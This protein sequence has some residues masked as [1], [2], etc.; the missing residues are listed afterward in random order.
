MAD[1]SIYVVAFHGDSPY[2]GQA[3]FYTSIA[4]IYDEFT[5]EELGITL[6]SLWA[7]KVSEAA[8]VSK[9]V[10]IS[11]RRLHSKQQKNRNKQQDDGG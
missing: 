1:K 9:F 4:A 11:R 7:R 10:V 3:H 5:A 2:A 8:Y 6:E